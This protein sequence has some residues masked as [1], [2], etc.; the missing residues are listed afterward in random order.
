MVAKPR[1]NLPVVCLSFFYRF[2]RTLDPCS[3]KHIPVFPWFYE[4]ILVLFSFSL[5]KDSFYFSSLDHFTTWISNMCSMPCEFLYFCINDSHIFICNVNTTLNHN[6]IY[7]LLAGDA[8]QW[9]VA[10]SVQMS[11][12]IW[13]QS[14]RYSATLPPNSWILYSYLEYRPQAILPINKT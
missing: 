9:P 10:D 3:I 2:C 4:H 13:K 11:H 1:E 5:P 6:L 12:S 7:D 8:G 14:L